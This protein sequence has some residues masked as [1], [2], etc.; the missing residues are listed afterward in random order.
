MAKIL[1]SPA[2]KQDLIE[3][4]DYIAQRLHNR[5]AA[6]NT[7]GR[8]QSAVF[9]LRDFPESGTPLLLPGV[10]ILYRYLVCGSYMVF[11]HLAEDTACIDRIPY[12]RRDYM[13]L[14]FGNVFEEGE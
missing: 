3:I 14:L 10:H 2:A 12:G 13:H 1:F 7:V 5:A 11:Y 4:G 8:I 6:R 9:H